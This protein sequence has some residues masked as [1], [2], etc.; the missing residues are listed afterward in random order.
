MSG[1][2]GDYAS[3]ELIFDNDYAAYQ[4][5]FELPATLEERYSEIQIEQDR[6]I[7]KFIASEGERFSAE[8]EAFF[9]SDINAALVLE[10]Y[11]TPLDRVGSVVNAFFN[12]LAR[13]ARLQPN[14]H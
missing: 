11:D 10:D 3:Y 4:L 5:E 12:L 1:Q 9:N 13:P 6:E 8:E 14:P 7:V 2:H